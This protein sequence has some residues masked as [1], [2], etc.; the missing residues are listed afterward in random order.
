[1]QKICAMIE[2]DQ[3]YE[4]LLQKNIA[5]KNELLQK[6][7]E[8]NR[9]Q[10]LTSKVSDVIWIL[11]LQGQ[12]TYVSPSVEQLRGFTV[13]EVYKQSINDVL[14]PASAQKALQLLAE[15]LDEEAKGIKKDVF[16]CYELE[17]TCKDGSTV[18]TEVITSANRD[19]QGN[20]LEFIGVSRNIGERIK[21]QAELN[22]SEE[23]Y[24]L[25]SEVSSDYVFSTMVLSN[26]SLELNWVSGAF[27]NITGFTFEEYKAKGGWRAF[28]HPDD[29]T[30]DDED[31]LNLFGNHAIK[32]E[33]RTLNKRGE[34]VWVQ[35]FA[36]P[37]WDSDRNALKS[38]YGA[39]RNITERKITEQKFRESKEKLSNANNLL[40]AV[41]DASS[42]AITMTNRKGEFQA[43]NKILLQRW[44]K[45]REEIVGFSAGKVLPPAVFQ[46]RVKIINECIEARE[47]V[48]FTDTY[49][50]KWFENTI[51]PIVEADGTI[52]NVAMFSRDITLLK[53]TLDD[54]KKNEEKFAKAFRCSPD[55]IL[56]TIL[57]EGKIVE[58]NDSFIALSGLTKDKCIGKTTIDIRLWI[59][60]EQRN[61]FTSLLQKN[62]SVQDF[63]CDFNFKGNVR[64][65]L[66]S[67]EIIS[68]ND[69]QYILGVIHD[70]TEQKTAQLKLENERKWLR[71]LIESIPDLV[72]LKDHDGVYVLCNPKFESF[73][74]AKEKD[75]IG[76][77]DYDFVDAPLADFFRENDRKAMM[78][79]KPSIN[80]EELVFASN[81]CKGLFETIK[82]P[83][84]DVEGHLIGVLG[85]SRDMTEL[86]ELNQNLEKKVEERTLQL[87][88]ANKDLEAF[89]Y[90]ISHD[91]RAPLRH[92]DG[93]SKILKDAIS[94]SNDETNRYFR[95]I[96]DSVIQMGQMIDDL[97]KFSRLGRKSIQK[98]DVDLNILVENVVN[99]FEQEITS[100]K[101]EIVIDKLPVI[102]GDYGLLQMVFENLISNAIKFTS[103]KEKAIIEVGYYKDTDQKNTIFV[104]DNGAGFD[105]AYANKLFGVFQRLHAQS[106]FEGTGIGLANVKQIIQKHGGTITAKSE[107]DNGATFFI[108]L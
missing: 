28:V 43:C 96:S 103:K 65:C 85:I 88:D 60:P 74:G 87:E 92:I 106:E 93:F 78:S 13:A 68:L 17:Q 12:F 104:K 23:R 67:A 82:T 56:I 57:N 94:D 29:L 5:L 24:R 30:K 64:N 15:T 25:I 18:W 83:V 40:Q 33:I 53:N 79:G 89:A 2:N 90:S 46:N 71:T 86:N 8:L 41:L 3:T 52:E 77:T 102:H 66:V 73:F 47:S 16:G 38:I 50:E 70:I 6:K 84:Y 45:T 49:N 21:I 99:Q 100:R 80:T 1:M 61:Q 63:E 97:L 37:L 75:I 69:E 59:I 10:I 39:V 4:A 101:I 91:L 76:K 26:G 54:L 108:T 22:R 27:E 107:I 14:T 11:N 51:E 48:T 32:S 105:M 36:H 81:G 34:V 55:P 31:L 62:G 58:A 98:T 20:L 9:Y 19:E 95:K 72:W 42:D 44:G 35:V 7:A